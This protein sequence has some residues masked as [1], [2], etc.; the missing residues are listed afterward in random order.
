MRRLLLPSL[1]L[2]SFFLSQGLQAQDDRSYLLPRVQLGKASFYCPSFH[3]NRTA[4]GTI[5]NEK[6]PVAAHPYYPFGTVI[7]VTNLAN[8]RNVEVVVIDRGPSKRHQKQG[9]IID[10]SRG[11]ARELGMLRQGRAR[12]RVEVLEW[13][14]HKA[15]FD[16]P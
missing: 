4:W 16:W 1:F 15:R 7:R 13:C 3:G 5:Y 2:F 8:N 14:P 6:E 11:A 9:G 10:L 12:V